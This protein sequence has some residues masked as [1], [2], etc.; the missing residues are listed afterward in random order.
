METDGR[1]FFL[2]FWSS[3]GVTGAEWEGAERGGGTM[4]REVGGSA[5]E[6]VGVEVGVD[7][8]L[9]PSPP[10]SASAAA[11]EADPAGTA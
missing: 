11:A 3:A 5:G 4:G 10:D 8:F 1:L 6:G 7:C 2:P 9:S